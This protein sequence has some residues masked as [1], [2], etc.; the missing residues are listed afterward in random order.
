MRSPVDPISETTQHAL[1]AV[2]DALKTAIIERVFPTLAQGFLLHAQQQGSPPRDNCLPDAHS[3]SPPLQRIYNATFVLIYRMLFLLYAEG[4]GLQLTRNGNGPESLT[5]FLHNFTASNV[6]SD[7]STIYYDRLQDLFRIL[8]GDAGH[9]SFYHGALFL[10]VPLTANAQD[11]I[12]S[13]PAIA[14]FLCN[15]KISDR[16]LATALAGLIH[17]KDPIT[18]DLMPI[19]YGNL[20]VRLLGTIYESLQAFTLQVSSE[21]MVALKGRRSDEIITYQEAIATRRRG[22]VKREYAPGEVYL[23]R[24]RRARRSTGS[25]YTPASIIQYILEHTL[26]PILEAKFASLEKRFAS[27]R[28]AHARGTARNDDMQDAELVAALFDIKVLDPAMGCGHFL[29]A[30]V[31]YIAIRM[32]AFLARFPAHPTLAELVSMRATLRQENATCEDPSDLDLLKRLV[33]KRCIFGVDLDAMAVEIANISLGLDSFIVGAPLPFLDAHLR[34]GNALIGA[35][36]NDLCALDTP[37][38][39]ILSTALASIIDVSK[40]SDLTPEQVRGSKEKFAQARTQ[41]TPARE[42]LASHLTRWFG[43]DVQAY[44]SFHWELEFPE[45]FLAA[46]A[47]RAGFDAIIGNPPYINANELNRSLSAR[48]KPYWKAHFASAAGA[49]DIYLLF[50]ELAIRLSREQGYSAFITPNK[51]LAAPY[52][53]AFRT[54]YSHAAKMLRLLDASNADIFADPS[55]YPIVLVSQ[56]RASPPAYTIETE[57]L[58]GTEGGKLPPYYARGVTVHRSEHLDVLPEKLWSFLLFD[59]LLPLLL[60]AQSVSLQLQQCARVRAST[61]AS[62]ADAYV[63]ALANEQVGTSMRFINTGLIERY[64]TLWSMEP[65]IHKGRS[66]STPYLDVASD[67][68]STTRGSQYAAPKLI[69]AKMARGIEAFLDEEGAFAS[70][71]TTF[72]FSSLYD[73][74]YL[75]ALL[76]SAL[77]SIIYTG[78]FGALRMSGGYSQFQAPQLRVLPIR[79]VNFVTPAAER[80]AYLEEARGHYQ[81][82]LATTDPSGVLSFVRH[83]LSRCPE[84]SD[85]VHDL[86]A[87]MA[88][89]MQ[90]LNREVREV[91]RSSFAED[92]TRRLALTNKLID[93]VVYQLYDISSDEFIE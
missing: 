19:D 50:M 57:R 3:L 38:D 80:A 73:L 89:T 87:F 2:G 71:N 76:N 31:N 42:A 34:C 58:L 32:Q 39:E 83:H 64:A 10:T 91:P 45:V 92:S 62:E 44:R 27:Y 15:N 7:E 29:V 85:V 93:S 54:Y 35:H 67:V 74:K 68:V 23:V 86:L 75:L 18:H 65:L 12:S 43:N 63:T 30:A 48:E 49:Y 81:R 14:R 13:M 26:S 11:G 46:S 61:S 82:Y 16:A 59:D 1:D 22:R 60:K 21:K 41:I 79:R 17:V 56:A 40:C 88:G 84:R 6:L 66:F 4:R 5:Q 20:P 47:E 24:N 70:A 78:Y 77:L 90:R 28:D 69:V 36:P 33:L 72:V 51:F 53:S 52:A 8:N 55:V 9:S 37:H 25:F